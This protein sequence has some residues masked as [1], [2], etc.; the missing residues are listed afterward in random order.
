MILC[1][2]VDDLIFTSNDDAM[3]EQFKK[4]ME[5]DFDMTDLRRM[6]YFLG[7]EVLQKVDGIFITQRKYAQEILKRFNMA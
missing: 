3:F 6:K 4:S 1:L 2:Y 7:I 5:I